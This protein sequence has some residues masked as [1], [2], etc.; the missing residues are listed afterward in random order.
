[1]TI[2]PLWKPLVIGAA[3][4]GAG[5][6]GYWTLYE[7]PRQDRLAALDAQLRLNSS[8]EVP[9]RER[10][11]VR[12][13]LREIGATTLGVT[14]DRVDAQF[15]AALHRI[16]DSCRL[17]DVQI[18]TKEPADVKN[19]IGSLRRR[20]AGMPDLSKQIDFRIIRGD[21]AAT[22]SLEQVMRAT[23]LIQAQ[24]WVHRVESFSISPPGQGG[25]ERF[26]L[27]LGV[28][29]I[30]LDG[31]LAPREVREPEIAVLPPD[32]SLAW[33]GIV[34]KNPFREPPRRT[35]ENPRRQDQR[36]VTQAP[37]PP[38]PPPPPPY[39]EWR[40]TGV[41][42]SRL[43]TEAFLVNTRSDERTAI[44]A[45]SSIAGAK[46]VAAEGERA[47]FEIE[48]EEYEVFNG[49]TLEQRRPRQR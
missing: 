38:P 1:V 14:R 31:D 43:G 19:P 36:Q 48:G 28:S 29:T 4:V 34:Q 32:A 23:S 9:T 40:L 7:N 27:R 16:A 25:D 45:G 41:V 10:A 26:V 8:L 21:V 3:L 15:R 46:L 39:N 2:R 47:I 11:R 22:G 37:P 13:E 44:G 35:A 6:L 33:A 12:Q 49:Q 18:S 24:P 5:V 17:G 42:E 30:M 20:I